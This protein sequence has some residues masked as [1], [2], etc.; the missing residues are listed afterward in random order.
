MFGNR[1]SRLPLYLRNICCIVEPERILISD[2]WDTYDEITALNFFN[3]LL[4]HHAFLQRF[5]SPRDF[6]DASGSGRRIS[7]A[8]ATQ[9]RPRTVQERI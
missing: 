2:D 1:I 8:T 6:E 3:T 4:K 7:V 9:N 5:S